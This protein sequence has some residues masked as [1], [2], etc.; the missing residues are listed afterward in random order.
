M[1]LLAAVLACCCACANAATNPI[2]YTDLWS[3][4]DEPGWGMTIVQQQDTL[5]MTIFVYGASN[6][7]IWYVASDVTATAAAPNIFTGTLYR[8][9]APWFGASSFKGASV[10]PVGIVR[11]Q[12][13]DNTNLLYSV[14]GVFVSK[15]VAR[16]SFRPVNIAGRYLGGSAGIWYPCLGNSPAY[17]ESAATYVV[18]HTG[19]DVQIREEGAGF[20]CTYTGTFLQTG[21]L[22]TLQTFGTCS[23]AG[24]PS[25][26]LFS[27]NVTV[28]EAGLSMNIGMYSKNGC[29]FNGQLGG[30]RLR[31]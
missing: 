5:F 31:P 8:G 20:Q 23:G 21:R 16:N 11:F 10:T 28:S 26:E 18:T 30:I 2:D 1:K 7:P 29:V 3:N 24:T 25:A 22:G 15:P 4:P 27:S 17:V 9:S 14:D 13:G 12:V 19:Y 6:Q